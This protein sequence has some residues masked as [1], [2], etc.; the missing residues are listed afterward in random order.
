MSHYSDFIDR[1]RA[2]DDLLQKL[3]PTEPGDTEALLA[4]RN[5]TDE[6]LTGG[7]PVAGRA[8]FPLVRAALL[9]AF[10]AIDESHRIVQDAGGDL[11]AYLHG[12]IHRREG[13]FDNARYWFRR[14][15]ALPFFDELRRAAGG[16]SADVAKQMS[17]DPYLFTGLCEQEKFGDDSHHDELVKLQRTEFDV[18]FDYVWR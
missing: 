9:Y 5:A 14:S 12:M 8:T 17:W 13:D 7:K 11:A 4:V 15:G 6:A 18:F 3:H 16:E 2:R 10:D 1:L